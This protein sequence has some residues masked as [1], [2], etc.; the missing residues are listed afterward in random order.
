MSLEIKRHTLKCCVLCDVL[1]GLRLENMKF[2]NFSGIV[3]VRSRRLELPLRLRN[4]DLN[5][6]LLNATHPSQ[7]LKNMKFFRANASQS[8]FLLSNHKGTDD[9][10][11]TQECVQCVTKCVTQERLSQFLSGSATATN[12]KDLPSADSYRPKRQ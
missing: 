1:Q 5:A 8:H 9:T 2:F 6:G 12:D 4:S 3:M 11:F 10:A 7:P